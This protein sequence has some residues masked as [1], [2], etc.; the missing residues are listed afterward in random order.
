MTEH[1]VKRKGSVRS[2]WINQ[3]IEEARE[4]MLE[5]H[6]ELKREGVYDMPRSPERA[7]KAM[8]IYQKYWKRLQPLHMLLM[9]MLERKGD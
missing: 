9:A 5:Y 3:I 8:K 2:E 4:A 6:E 7:I 1:D